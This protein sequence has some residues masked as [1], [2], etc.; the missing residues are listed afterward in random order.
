MGPQIAYAKLS[1]LDERFRNRFFPG[2]ELTAPAK[3]REQLESSW[4]MVIEFIGPSPEEEC[5]WGKVYFLAEKAPHES[6]YA[7]N[8]FDLLDGYLPVIRAEI[9]D[10]AEVK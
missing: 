3:F 5:Y 9:I 1:V 7:G 4:S 2:N 8:E 6:L 10:S